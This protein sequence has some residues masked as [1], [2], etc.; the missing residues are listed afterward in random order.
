MEA[1]LERVRYAI[2]DLPEEHRENVLALGGTVHVVVRVMVDEETH[3]FRAVEIR[4]SRPLNDEE[5]KEQE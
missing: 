5:H 4:F 1:L 2:D 3:Q